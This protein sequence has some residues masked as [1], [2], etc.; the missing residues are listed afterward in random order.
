MR[1]V[2]LRGSCLDASVCAALEIASLYVRINKLLTDDSCAIR[3]ARCYGIPQFNLTGVADQTSY[4]NINGNYLRT[5]GD[6]IVAAWSPRDLSLSSLICD[7]V[8]L[9]VPVLLFGGPDKK[10]VEIF[11]K[12][13]PATEMFPL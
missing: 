12:G 11:P 7:S 10:A 4:S 1:V 6:L 8:L 9:G 5:K 13:F 3:W 2:L